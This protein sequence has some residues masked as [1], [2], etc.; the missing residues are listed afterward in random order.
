MDPKETVQTVMDAL[1]KGDFD[2]ARTYLSNDFKFSGP[3]PEP[4]NAD[5][6]MGVSKTLKKAF[7]NLDYQFKIEGVEG[8]VVKTSAQL[9]GT[10]DGDIDLSAFHMG[11]IPATKK[12]F[13]VGRE[14]GKATVKDGKVTSWSNEPSADAGLMAILGQLGVKPPAM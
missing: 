4:I 1:Q 3:I 9:K 8:D 2:K 11:V 7:S 10:N 14:P 6:W 13:A 12:S 5:A